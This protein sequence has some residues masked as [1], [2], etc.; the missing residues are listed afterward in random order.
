VT[1][2]QRWTVG[3]AAGIAVLALGVLVG[4]RLLHAAPS[5]AAKAYVSV[6]S[7]PAGVCPLSTENGL[8]GLT[9]IE[10]KL[11]TA[12][13]ALRLIAPDATLSARQAASSTPASSYFWVIAGTGTYYLS[14]YPRPPDA[15]AA[16][17]IAHSV[18]IFVRANQCAAGG[19]IRLPIIRL[20]IDVYGPGDGLPLAGVSAY[21]DYQ[22]P[23]SFD[24][25][26][27]VVDVKIR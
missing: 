16:M 24:P 2:P 18:L 17:E 21:G 25:L 19:A 9:R 12:E 26:P 8:T 7:L 4:P 6:E 20:P 22:W 14:A 3:V 23:A 13:S 11:V 27:A 1:T 15:T 5:R 10:A